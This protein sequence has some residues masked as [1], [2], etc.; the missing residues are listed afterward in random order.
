MW[1]ALFSGVDMKA[2]LN[3]PA[4]WN[5]KLKPGIAGKT[6][7]NFPVEDENGK[8][9]VLP[10]A[11]RYI[12]AYSRG[13]VKKTR[14]ALV[15]VSDIP[16]MYEVEKFFDSIKIPRTLPTDDVTFLKDKFEIK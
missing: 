15:M 4:L 8:T 16:H 5:T 3:T 11:Y 13:K 10:I 2:I 9:V 12:K 1:L 7:K 6:F 14:W